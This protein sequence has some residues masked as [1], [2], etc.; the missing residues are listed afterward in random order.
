AQANARLG[1]A[2]SPSVS[3]FGSFQS[4]RESDLFDKG[5]YEGRLEANS[6]R[7]SMV[8]AVKKHLVQRDDI[9]SPKSPNLE[10]EPFLN[11][12]AVE[13]EGELSNQDYSVSHT[14]LEVMLPEIY[15]NGTKTRRGTSSKEDAQ[16][17][18]QVS[19]S[20][21][22]CKI[23]KLLGWQIFSSLEVFVVITCCCRQKE[24]GEQEILS[25]L[26][27]WIFLRY[28]VTL[29]EMSIQRMVKRRRIQNKECLMKGLL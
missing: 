20:K 18:L 27:F 21:L 11:T 6:S 22:L 12:E 24:K 5:V 26:I 14:L 10:A 7:S 13:S 19:R 3:P 28:T 1:E 16:N 17:P 2:V 9:T 8:Q 25:P 23:H 15:I 29:P 4:Q